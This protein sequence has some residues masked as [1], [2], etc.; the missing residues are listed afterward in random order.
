MAVS[1][2]VGKHSRSSK[3]EKKKKKFAVI[4]FCVMVVLF[5]NSR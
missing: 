2:A 4:K 1:V 5:S 3:K